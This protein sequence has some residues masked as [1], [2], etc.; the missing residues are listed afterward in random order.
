MSLQQRISEKRKELDSLNQIKQLSENLATQLEQLEAK[1]DTLSEGSESVAI[2]LSN[3][4]NI[5]KSASLASMS[6]QNY[7]E[8][9]YENKD[10]PPLPETLVRLRIDE[11]N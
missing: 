6:L 4:N 10:D 11:D 9:D 5:I 3:W 2:V 7:T 8:G 1:L